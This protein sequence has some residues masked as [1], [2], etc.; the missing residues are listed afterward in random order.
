M[1]TTKE[2]QFLRKKEAA[3]LLG[4]SERQ[5]D[6]RVDAGNIRK[7]IG[8]KHPGETAAPAL[9]SQSDIEALK[10][11]KP[12]NHA[13]LV[14]TPATNGH[15][16]VE[17]K[18]PAGSGVAKTASSSS[19]SEEFWRELLREAVASF[20][21]EKP[22]ALLPWISLQ[23]AAACS[24]LPARYLRK[25]AEGGWPG[26]RNVGEKRVRWMFNRDA[27]REWC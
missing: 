9:Y 25:L 13:T 24:G 23:E 1:T 10:A 11:G 26:A 2:D 20:V 7:I 5:L 22:E 16:P 8:E 19:S 14:K 27:L 4:V 6:R 15:A 17:A 21:V 3:A 18:E 12:H